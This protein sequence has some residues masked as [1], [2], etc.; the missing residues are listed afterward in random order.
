MI[1][2]SLKWVSI[3]KEVQKCEVSQLW[4]QLVALSQRH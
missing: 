2:Q 4:F 1:P 3:K